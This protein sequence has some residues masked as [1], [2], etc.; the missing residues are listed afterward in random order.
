MLL[1]LYIKLCFVLIFFRYMLLLKE[2]DEYYCKV[3][4]DFLNLEG[5]NIFCNVVNKMVF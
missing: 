5:K 1:Y 2:I 3:M 4:V